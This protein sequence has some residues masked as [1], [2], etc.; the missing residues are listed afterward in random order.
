MAFLTQ[1]TGAVARGTCLPGGVAELRDLCV[2]QIAPLPDVS[3]SDA[4]FDCSD[5]GESREGSRPICFSV[6]PFPSEN[7]NPILTR[8]AFIPKG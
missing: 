6:S 8:T 2:E 3:M 4:L 1:P 5:L 7:T